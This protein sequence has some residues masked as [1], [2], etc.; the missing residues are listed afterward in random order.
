M[1][2]RPRAAACHPYALTLIATL[3]V[4][5]LGQAAGAL[6]APDDDPAANR[7]KILEHRFQEAASKNLLVKRPS[8]KPSMTSIITTWTWTSIPALPP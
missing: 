1:P 3:V 8:T 4:L 6:A 2:T 5:T 7:E